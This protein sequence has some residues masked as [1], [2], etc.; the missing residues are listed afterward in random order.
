MVRRRKLRAKILL[1]HKA[2][3]KRLLSGRFTIGA[4]HRDGRGGMY[5]GLSVQGSNENLAPAF[6]GEEF[7]ARDSSL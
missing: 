5:Y 4:P 1:M 3:M 7:R 6:G 2:G